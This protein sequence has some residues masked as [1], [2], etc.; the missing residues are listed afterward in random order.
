[1]AYLLLLGA[2]VFEVIATSLLTATEGFTRLLP[3]VVWL[4]GYG[5]AFFLLAGA[6]ERGMSVGVG[7]ALWSGL[8]TTAIVIIGALVLGQAITWVTGLGIG[9]II[10]GVMLVNLSGAAA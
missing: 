4:V 5:L 6:I 2:I 3:T 8:G 10:A 7:Y 1:M 9:L